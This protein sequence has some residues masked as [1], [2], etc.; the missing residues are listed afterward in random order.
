MKEELKGISRIENILNE[1][2][3]P[4]ECTAK[5]GNE[6][7]Y[8]SVDNIIEFTLVFPT[9]DDKDFLEFAHQLRPQVK[10]DVFLISLMHE[11]GHAE[12]MDE[13]EDSEYFSMR[14]E[15][16]I[17][18]DSVTQFVIS[19]SEANFQ[20]FNIPDEKR[21]TEWGLDYMINHS[22]E[23]SSLWHNLQPAILDFYRINNIH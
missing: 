1:F 20:Y 11:L 4:F 7:T 14:D 15:K 21:A 19:R 5:L 18:S 6:F 22:Q 13:W 23:I 10:A 3:A 16:D 12:T 2:L 9:Q 17:I 8:C